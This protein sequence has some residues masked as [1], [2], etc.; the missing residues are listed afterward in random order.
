MPY[1]RS[2]EKRLAKQVMWPD[3]RYGPNGEE[4]LFYAAHEVPE[5]WTTK[6]DPGY[7]PPDQPEHDRDALV[8]K[9]Q[10]NGIEINPI[11]GKAHMQKVLDD[12][13]SSR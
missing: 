1:S 12:F 6:P 8:A 3:L 11:W 7:V 10:A 9:L 4:K 2:K 5:G 13:S